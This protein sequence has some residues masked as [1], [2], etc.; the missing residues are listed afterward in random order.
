MASISAKRSEGTPH[1][2]AWNGGWATAVWGCIIMAVFAFLHWAYEARFAWTAGIDASSPE[3]TRYYR[4]LLWAQLILGAAGT[5]IWWGWLVR[6]GRQIVDKTVTHEEEVRRIAVFWGLIAMTSLCLYIMASFWPAQDGS[7][8]QTAIRDTALTPPHIAMFYLWFP[9]GITF[10]IGTYL[11]GRYRIPKVYGPGKGFPWSF[12]L[13]IAASVTEMMQV[14]FN[15]WAHSLWIPEEIFAAPFHWPFVT[16]GWLA[17]G[18]FALWGET[19]L[20]L[21]AI[22]NEAGTMVPAKVSATD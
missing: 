14:A 12:G 4:T 3:F 15:E 13:L 21:L 18:I 5:G 16:Y 7:W 2:I 19:I 10:T 1:S 22:E 17:A 20:R 9:L 6:T 8:H 11:Y